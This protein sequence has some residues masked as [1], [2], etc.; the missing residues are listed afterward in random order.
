MTSELP[1][2]Q[3]HRAAASDPN[4][5]STKMMPHL[6]PQAQCYIS[7]GLYPTVDNYFNALNYLNKKYV[8]GTEYGK[9]YP[10]LTFEIVVELLE[11]S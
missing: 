11:L 3:Y 9:L 6:L 1:T 5:L 4:R 7:D 10:T 2:P 8:K